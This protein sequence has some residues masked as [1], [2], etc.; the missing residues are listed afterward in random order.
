[1]ELNVRDLLVDNDAAAEAALGLSRWR[2][3]DRPTTS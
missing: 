3:L 2:K 1:M